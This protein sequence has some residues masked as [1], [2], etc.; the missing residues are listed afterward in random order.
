MSATSSVLFHTCTKYK[1]LLIKYGYVQHIRHREEGPF[2]ICILVS[3][4]L[5]GLQ[6]LRCE[7]L[8]SA[9]SDFS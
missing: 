7:S 8:S 5:T 3:D 9:E 2:F 1:S 4:V 6:I